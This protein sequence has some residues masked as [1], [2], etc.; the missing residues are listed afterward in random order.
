MAVAERDQMECLLTGVE[1]LTNTI[2]RCRIYEILYLDG[3]QYQQTES[4]IKPAFEN[5]TA[6][7]ISLYAAVLRFFAKAYRAFSKSGFRRARD[8]FNPGMFE[9]LL[10]QSRV[11]D[12]EV[13]AAV[14]SC[15]EACNRNA[16]RNMEGLSRILKDLE[17]PVQRIDSGVKALLQSVDTKRRTEILQWISAIPYEDNHNTA[18]MGHTSGTGKWLLQH[19]TYIEWTKSP[20]YNVL[21]LYGIRKSLMLYLM[22]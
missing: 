7:L 5:L 10:E 8:A 17:G 16:H 4:R 13:A 18:A 20:T 1:R 14:G 19:G 11:L 21:W 2:S 12:A 6:A 3:I 9:G 22:R 15:K